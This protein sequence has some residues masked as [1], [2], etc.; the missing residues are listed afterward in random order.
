[1]NG[2]LY[3]LSWHKTILCWLTDAAYAARVEEIK[4]KP[5]DQIEQRLTELCAVKGKLPTPIRKAC[6]KYFKAQVAGD[7]AMYKARKALDKARDA[8]DKALDKA[9][10]KTDDKARDKSQKARV[11]YDKAM[12]KAW[13]AWDKAREARDK[14]REAR[15]EIFAKYKTEIEA[16]HKQECPD[17]KWNGT[18]IVFE[19]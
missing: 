2:K 8:G 16:L 19:K 10:D 15:D 4:T 13:D 5:A 17:S 18:E 11:A 12:D 1:M 14:A 9:Y 7:K 6:K 3:W